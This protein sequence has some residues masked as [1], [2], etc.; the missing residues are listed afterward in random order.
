MTSDIA[1][2]QIQNILIQECFI[3]FIEHI[4]GGTQVQNGKDFISSLSFRVQCLPINSHNQ[5]V[6]NVYH[7]EHSTELF[8]KPSSNFNIQ[9]LQIN[10]L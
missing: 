3:C 4:F 7:I 2:W 5:P 6:E 10:E 8:L 9:V 1:E